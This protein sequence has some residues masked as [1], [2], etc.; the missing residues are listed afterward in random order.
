MTTA[1]PPRTLTPDLRRIADAG[2]RDGFFG[3]SAELT[4]KPEALAA[5]QAAIDESGRA[6]TATERNTYLVYFYY[7]W[8][9]LR[10][11]R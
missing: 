1:A 6:W 5:L 4:I 11:G 8:K 9:Y 3:Y 10:G 2:K 7:A